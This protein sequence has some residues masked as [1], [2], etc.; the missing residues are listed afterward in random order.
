MLLIQRVKGILYTYLVIP[1][2]LENKGKKGYLFLHTNPKRSIK[3]PKK[4]HRQARD[5]SDDEDGF[6]F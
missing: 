5:R 6:K 4:C 2:F 1:H 3:N